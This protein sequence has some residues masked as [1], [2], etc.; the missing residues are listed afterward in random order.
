MK[1]VFLLLISTML[2]QGCAVS[3][4]NGFNG[5]AVF[6]EYRN[7]TNYTDKL[8]AFIESEKK[9]DLK[10][11]KT[12]PKRKSVD[13]IDMPVFKQILIAP[14]FT[15]QTVGGPIKGKWVEKMDVSGCNGPSNLNVEVTASEGSGLTFKVIK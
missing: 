8:A 11:C 3:Q 14:I 10:N 12:K 5:Q 7:R 2:L 6:N 9:I 4:T 15:T 1:H 13:V